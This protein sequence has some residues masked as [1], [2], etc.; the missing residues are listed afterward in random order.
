MQHLDILTSCG[1]RVNLRIKELLLNSFS[2]RSLFLSLL[3]FRKMPS[4]QERAGV[5]FLDSSHPSKDIIDSFT[6]ETLTWTLTQSLLV[7]L[8]DK[9]G[10]TAYIQF[11]LSSI[12]SVLCKRYC[13]PDKS[14]RFFSCYYLFKF[15]LT[16]SSKPSVMGLCQIRVEGCV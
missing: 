13:I 1:N 5:P 2:T 14:D 12:A 3:G 8:I 10:L 7:W 6:K 16:G 9:R 11:T 15:Y 4:K